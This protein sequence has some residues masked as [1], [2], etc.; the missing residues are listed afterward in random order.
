[1]SSKRLHKLLR[2]LAEAMQRAGWERS[3]GGNHV[4]FTA[5]DGTKIGLPRSSK[6]SSQR[7]VANIR[8][9]IRRA[10]LDI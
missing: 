3:E 2:P 6:T 8:A 7:Q 4:C 5:P 10:G 1:M 9:Q